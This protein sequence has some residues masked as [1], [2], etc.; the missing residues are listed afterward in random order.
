MML[1][2]VQTEN[3]YLSRMLIDMI[4]RCLRSPRC[5]TPGAAIAV[6]IEDPSPPSIIE[7][8]WNATTKAE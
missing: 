5:L 6:S 3:E 2:T 8:E 7:R 4:D 1:R